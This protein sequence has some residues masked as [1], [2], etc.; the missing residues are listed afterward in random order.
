MNV[1]QRRSF[2]TGALAGVSVGALIGR[3]VWARAEPPPPPPPPPPQPQEPP[4]GRLSFAQQGEDLVLFHILRDLLEITAPTY[5][6]IGAAEPVLGSNT[7]LLYCTGG[8]GVLVE[9]NPAYVEKLR[10][11]R[12]NDVV[13]AAGVGVGKETEADYYVIRGQPPLNTFSREV[14]EEMRAKAAS[15]PV[16]RVLK[17]PLVP[18]NELIATHLGKAP[19]L[20]SIDVEGLDLAI[21]RTL[22]FKKY[23]PG[24]IIAETIPMKANGVNTELASFLLSKRY[25]V[26]GG[27]SINTVFVDRKR[28]R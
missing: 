12:P 2:L 25:V 16:E 19:D 6:D 24:A 8:R 10:L 4:E 23:R 15:D 20:L 26:R 11:R 1:I 17:M 21:L 5:V 13:V 3:A 7:Y 18:L 9:P 27:S 14:V 22:D 28:L